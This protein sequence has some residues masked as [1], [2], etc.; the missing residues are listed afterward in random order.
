MIA[1]TVSTSKKVGTPNYGSHGA[2]CSLGNIELDEQLL[3][4]PQALA[5]KIR[6][7]YALAQTAV[8]E[9]LARLGNGQAAAPAALHATPS[10][11]TRPSRPPA[12][13]LPPTTTPDR[14]NE[15]DDA[16]DDDDT[17]RNGSQLLGWARK[18]RDDC[19]GFIITLGKKQKFAGRV[20]EWKV[21][22]VL[23]AFHATKQMLRNT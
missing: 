1:L 3:H 9:E 5:A 12:P 21:D 13:Q 20:V 23:E 8:D 4:D 19:M 2:T 14:F 17:P 11:P 22:Q 18:Q 6:A 10:T 16:G 7:W 15:E